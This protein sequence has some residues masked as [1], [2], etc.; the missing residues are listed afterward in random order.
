MLKHTYGWASDDYFTQY[1]QDRI[2]E[3]ADYRHAFTDG[4]A[5]PRFRRIQ[6]VADLRP[7]DLVAVDY[8]GQ[9]PD[10]T[11]HIVMVREVKGVFTGVADFTGETQYAVGVIDCTA[12]PHGVYGL[13]NYPKYPDTRMVALAKEEQLEGVGIGHMMFYASQST[14]EFTRYRWSVNTARDNAYPVTSRPIA[15]ARI[16]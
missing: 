6:K 3:A 9:V 12:E 8:A 16:T 7:G 2:P 11:G 15:A 14:G 1:F 5:G 10:N 4:T 13:T